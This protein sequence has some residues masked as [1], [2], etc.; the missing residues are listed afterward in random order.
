M[1]NQFEAYRYV[2][3]IPRRVRFLRLVWFLVW[4]IAFR[5]TPRWALHGWR[6]G[7]LRAFGAK[8]GNGSRIS[9]SARIWAPW[10]LVM[11]DYSV[12]AEGVDCYSMDKIVIG[13]KVAVSQ[14]SY[15]CTGSHDIDSLRRPLITKPI[16]IQDHVWICA[17]SFVGPGVS[18]G[19]GAVVGARAV[20]VRD[21]PAWS[22]VGG[23][24]ARYIKKRIVSEM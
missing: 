19:E 3:L 14:R 4:L 20:V 24:P 5:P 17:E 6:R 15:L 8:V 13:S 12:L 22:V 10:N 16:V 21:I 1:S 2:D 7:L 9:P 23:N 11:G 18:I